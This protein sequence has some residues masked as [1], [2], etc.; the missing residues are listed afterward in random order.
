MG[1]E[2]A[3]RDLGAQRPQRRRELLD[4]RLGHRTG[5]RGV[6]GRPAPLGGV[7][8]EGELT[9]HEDRGGDIGGTEFV[10]EDAQPPHLVG[11]LARHRG[12]I[13]VGEPDERHQALR[14]RGDLADCLP[15]DRHPRRR[16]PLHQYPHVRRCCHSCLWYL[17]WS[18][19]AHPGAV[20]P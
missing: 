11:H 16:H 5:R 4:Q 18:W 8:I 10:V 1:A 17:W 2:P 12:I 19:T 9:D 13:G 3:A 6:P 7:G 15:I 14:I 20:L